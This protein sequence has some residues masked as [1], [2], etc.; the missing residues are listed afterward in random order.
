M[1]LPESFG[2]VVGELP[3]GGRLPDG[4]EFPFGTLRP[5]RDGFVERN[6]VKS[7]YAVYGEQ[8][9]WIAFAPIFQ[10]T[11][12]QMLKAWCLTSRSTSASSPWTCAAT[13]APTGRAGRQ[14]YA[15]DEYYAD[16]VAALD[17]AGVDKAALIGISATAMTAL[18]FAAEHPERATHVIIVGGYAD[19][20]IDEP[21]IAERVRAE[22][23][24]M[25]SDWPKYLE[26][27]F[28]IVFTEPHSTKPFEDGV[29]YGWAASGELV[30]WGRNGW[31]ESDVTALARRIKC[32]TLVIHGDGDKRVPI[33][34][35]RAIRDLV[36]GAQ[37]LT[38]G[39]GGHLPSA[40][41]P[42][43]FNRAVRDF[44]AGRPARRHLGA[45]MSRKRR[46]LFIS[47]PIGLGHVQRDLA[48]ARELRKLQPELD[49]DWFTVDPAAR[50]LEQ[51]GER[52]HPI[53][54]AWRTR[55]GTSSPS[56]ASTTCTRSSRCAPW[57][58]SWCA[59]S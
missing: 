41:D 8:G 30:D 44:V 36:P 38:V 25:R 28:S 4:Q 51:E 29:R 48:I 57:T 11:H 39:G 17:A 9:P 46:A 26:W 10:I 18:R 50:Y 16:F 23:D 53:T 40:R 31:L 7:W 35:G 58:R 14:H 54:S 20:R 24:R 45:R 1:K 55:A 49:I 34:K 27:F 19:A 15:F 59:T 43:L 22:S 2:K 33:A 13:A 42:V 3:V 32:P 12:S 56:P 5:V 37:L 6:D 52:L 21:K 47:S